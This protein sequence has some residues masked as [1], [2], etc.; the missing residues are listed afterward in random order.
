[1][2]EAAAADAQATAAA[3]QSQLTRLTSNQGDFAGEMTRQHGEVIASLQAKIA[4]LESAN[5]AHEASLIERDASISALQSR[6]E[7]Q[8]VRR[9]RD[10]GRMQARIDAMTAE[11]S[12][13]LTHT[14]RSLGASQVDGQHHIGVHDGTTSSGVRDVLALAGVGA[15]SSSGTGYLNR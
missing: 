14:L 12:D 1:M 15:V 9:E 2:A 8:G 3:L 5:R 11:F 4:A 6:L 10:L 13:M 7:E